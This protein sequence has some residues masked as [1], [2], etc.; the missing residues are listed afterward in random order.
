MG[1][2]VC[3]SYSQYMGN[4]LS[5]CAGLCVSLSLCV[6]FSL[7]LHLPHGEHPEASM[8]CVAEGCNDITWSRG[9]CG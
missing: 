1:R 8:S 5:T 6:H 3:K 2:I 7:S 4:I 9:R